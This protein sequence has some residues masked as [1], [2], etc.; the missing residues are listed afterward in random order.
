VVTNPVSN[1]KLAVGRAF[2]YASVRAHGIPVG[3]GTDGASSNNSLDL[4]A[5]VK[6]L[7][8]LQKFNANDPAALPATEAWQVATGA[9][10]PHLDGSPTL[11]VGERAD[12]VLAR[13]AAPELA[14]GHVLDNLVYAASGSVLT[15]AVVAGRVLMHDGVVVG[16]DGVHEDEVRARVVE[17]AGRL[18]VL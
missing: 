17:C 8:L 2:P 16:A 18:G 15:T 10:A 12:F 1:L 6:V 13:A 9:L 14:P 7:A 4:V 5:D 11:A 3:L